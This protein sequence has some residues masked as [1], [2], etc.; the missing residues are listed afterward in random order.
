[1]VT[2]GFN[3]LT[4]ENNILSQHNMLSFGICVVVL[5]LSFMRTHELWRFCINL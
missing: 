5:W 2:L 1:M 3:L 4:F